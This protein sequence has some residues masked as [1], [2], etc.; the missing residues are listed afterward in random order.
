MA[1]ILEKEKLALNF[2]GDYSFYWSW[3][4][5]YSQCSLQLPY[6]KGVNGTLFP[7]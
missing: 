1:N 2:G 7:R 5:K 4:H 6:Y 3:K